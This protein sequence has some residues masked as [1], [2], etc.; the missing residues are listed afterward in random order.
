VSGFDRQQHAVA[1][2][3][4]GRDERHAVVDA[5]AVV[6]VVEAGEELVALADAGAVGHR[7]AALVQARAAAVV[8]GLGGH[9][10]QAQRRAL[11]G[12][13][14]EVAGGAH[15][16]VVAQG[17]VDLVLVDQARHLADLVDGAA[18]GAAAEQH[19]GR[20][21]QDLHAV[22][23]EGVA[24]VDG[25]VAHAVDEQ[26]AGG[27]QREAAQADVFLAALGGQEGDAGGVLQRFLDGVEVAVVDQASRSPR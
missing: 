24:V 25:G 17:Q 20:A 4:G 13:D 1:R 27:L 26:V 19:R 6:Q 15:V 23:G 8:V 9:G 21:A 12:L 14:V 2:A 7:H 5:V 16:L 3:A 11:T 22:D 18:G 10:V